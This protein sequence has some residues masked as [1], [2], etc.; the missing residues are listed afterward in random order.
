MSS[1]PDEPGQPDWPACSVAVV[2][3]GVSGEAAARTLARL[4]AQVVVLDAAAGE[5]QQAAADRL[6]PLGVQAR[7]GGLPERPPAGV[8]LVVTSPGVRP[9]TP[10]IATSA[11][12]VWGEVELAWRLRPAGQRWLG[13][14]GTNG[15]T[16]TTQLLGSVLQ[17]AGVRSATAGN[18]GTPLLDAVG[19]GDPYAV[20]AVELSSFQL[21][22]TSSLALDAAAVLNLADDHLD[23]HGGFAGYAADKGRIWAGSGV[24][25]ANRDDAA[26]MAL[27]RLV[28][29]ERFVTFG[30]G[31]VVDGWL[32]DAGFGGGALLPAGELQLPGAHNVTNALAAALL[33]RAIDVPVGAV[34]AGLAGLAPG[35]HRNEL[36]TEFGGVAYVDDSKA[37]NPHAAAASLGAYPS[38]VWV[39]GGLNKGLRFDD[40]VAR[41]ADRLRAAV[42]IGTCAAEVRAALARHAPDVPVVDAGSMDDAVIE[43]ARLAQR[44]D[45]VLLAPAAASMDM[46]RDY[47]E[48]GAAFAAAAR[49]LGEGTVRRR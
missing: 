32:T 1:W 11:V 14:T 38:V 28:R 48:R 23:W 27:A 36:V 10:L 39:A 40:L 18:I 8:G 45:T 20:L 24:A 26:T 12:P 46:F 34:R 42:L 4:G 35:P 47:A 30:L 15:K 21:H 41:A 5:R 7:L 3:A 25:V 37:T 16:T 19:A 49:R 9:G 13:V 17:A 29:G 6:A 31:D 33:A 22:Y 2:G 44:G 43:A